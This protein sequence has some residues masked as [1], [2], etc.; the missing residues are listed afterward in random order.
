MYKKKTFSTRLHG[1]HKFI[2]NGKNSCV[3]QT[4]VSLNVVSSAVTMKI[5]PPFVVD[6]VNPD[7]CAVTS[8]FM[9]QSIYLRVLPL[10]VLLVVT[11]CE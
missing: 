7:T 10:A 2:S 5:A 9:L 1:R 4:G 11:C 8:W 6:R 3:A